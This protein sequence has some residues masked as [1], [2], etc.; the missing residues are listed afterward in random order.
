MIDTLTQDIEKYVDDLVSSLPEVEKQ[1]YAEVL[2]EIKEFTLYSDGTIK[3]NLENIKRLGRIKKKMDDIV[4]NDEYLKSVSGFVA[5]YSAVEKTMNVYFGKLSSDFT[6]KKVL[7]EVTKQSVD[8]AVLALTESG[9]SVNVSTPIKEI[10]KVNVTSGGS[11]SSLAEQ[12]RSN[13]LSTKD[14]D[15]SL[16]KY[17]KT[18]ATDAVNTYAGSYMK[19]IT[20]DLGLKWYRFTGSNVAN[21]RAICKEMKIK[22]FIH[23]SEFDEMIKGKVNGKQLPL[24]KS[25]YPLGMKTGTTP[26]NYQQ[27]RN[28]WQCGHQLIPVSEASVPKDV[29]TS[30]Y[31]KKGIKYDGDGFAVRK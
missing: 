5:S 21:T 30:L 4:L 3:N 26:D 6:P 8:D 7:A 14:A 28:G 19:M 17:V 15:G 22:K 16:V 24:N 31:D 18:Y 27:V 23:V 2:K 25:G 12:L 9:I 13:I 1:L 10:I 29:R 11:Y 20:D